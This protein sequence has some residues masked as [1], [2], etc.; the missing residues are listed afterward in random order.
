VHT[1]PVPQPTVAQL[2][3]VHGPEL[4]MGLGTVQSL[5]EAHCTH[6]PKRQMGVVPEQVLQ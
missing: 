2:T 6:E 3:H 4:Q 5:L 1:C